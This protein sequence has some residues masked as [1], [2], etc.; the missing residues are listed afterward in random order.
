MKQ[1][2]TALELSRSLHGP[3]AQATKLLE[4]K[5]ATKGE[6]AL[7][8]STR[9]HGPNSETTQALAAAVQ[10][11]DRKPPNKPKLKM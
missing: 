1:D 8:L 9:L 3:D 6:T 11:Q 5:A 4:E 10:K 7:Q 2:K